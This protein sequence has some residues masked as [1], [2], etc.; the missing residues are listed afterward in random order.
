[1]ATCTKC[2]S[3]NLYTNKSKRIVNKDWCKACNKSA[4]KAK[5]FNELFSIIKS[6]V[7]E[8]KE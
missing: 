2:S 1:M 7:D 5:Q 6:V 8:V 4:Y 3:T